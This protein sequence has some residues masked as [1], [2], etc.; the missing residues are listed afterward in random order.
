MVPDS[1]LSM[2]VLRAID[3]YNSRINPLLEARPASSMGSRFEIVVE[4]VDCEECGLEDLI[5]C[6][7]DVMDSLGLEA[8][9]ESVE[10]MGSI[11]SI[12]VRVSPRRL[13]SAS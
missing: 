1:V 2:V 12:V 3:L 5:S 6:L 4:G 11:V 7:I 9:V 10:S 8:W 13:V